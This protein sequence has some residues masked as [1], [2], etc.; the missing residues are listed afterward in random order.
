MISYT[1]ITV[2]KIIILICKELRLRVEH[3]YKHSM[4]SF[5]VYLCRSA[6]VVKNIDSYSKLN[7]G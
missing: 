3:I 5:N 7:P 2:V 1:K 4:N 6:I